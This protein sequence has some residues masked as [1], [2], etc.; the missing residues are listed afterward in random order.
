MNER[1]IANV[2]MAAAWDGE[3]G[4]NWAAH[5]AYYDR[6]GTRYNPHLLERISPDDD[7]LDIGCGNGGP[8][9]DAARRAR[10]AVGIDLST[11]MLAYAR[12]RAME[13]G[14]DNVRFEQMDAQVHPFEP[15][16][17]DIAI[18]RQGA[19][20]FADPVAAFAN[21][22]RALRRGGRIAILGWQSIA[23]NE[24]LRLTRET[25][26]MGRELPAP[27]LGAPGPLGLADPEKNH[28]IFSEAGYENITNED[29]SEPL[30]FGADVADAFGFIS[31]TGP[32]RGML[33]DLSEGDKAKGLADLR[34]AIAAHARADGVWFGSRCWL[35]TATRP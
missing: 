17:F 12:E 31:S 35:V 34:E 11:Q 10:T 2:D 13:E 21:I 28:R 14:L 18:S 6:C 26:A 5:A 22:G 20:F 19:M 33:A 8:T 3:E 30:W 1:P 16:S 29:V 4:A 7:V 9:R 25:L 23:E 27:P 32:I 24:W 15:E